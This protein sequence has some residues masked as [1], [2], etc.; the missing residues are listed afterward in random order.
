MVLRIGK[1]WFGWGVGA[2]AG[3]RLDFSHDGRSVQHITIIGT[4][5]TVQAEEL[6]R[7]L[8]ENG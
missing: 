4:L 8:R 6:A 1:F 3:G 7:Q 2:P 5:D